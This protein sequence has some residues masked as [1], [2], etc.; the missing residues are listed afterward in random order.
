MN[1]T[2][3]QGPLAGVRVLDWTHVLAG[4]FAGYMLGQMGA[5][6]IRFDDINGGLDNDRWPVTKNGRS[7]YWAGLN[8]G[9]RSIAVE[10]D[11]RCSVIAFDQFAASAVRIIQRVDVV[12][13]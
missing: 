7:I 8:K 10:G 2:L 9:K 13:H 6:V 4:P 1:P 11:D 12:A 5:D 3:S